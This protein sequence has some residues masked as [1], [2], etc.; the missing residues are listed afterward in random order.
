MDVPAVLRFFWVHD[1]IT[2]GINWY[3]LPKRPL[4]RRPSA[5][6]RC[7]DTTTHRRDAWVRCGSNAAQPTAHG[8]A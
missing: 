5:L 3:D 2:T 1:R 6:R 8:P 4:A 7:T